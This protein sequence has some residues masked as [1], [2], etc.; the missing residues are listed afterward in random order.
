VTNVAFAFFADY[1]ASLG[2]PRA[3]EHEAEKVSSNEI[4]TTGRRL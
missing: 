2:G 1:S 4:N 3:N